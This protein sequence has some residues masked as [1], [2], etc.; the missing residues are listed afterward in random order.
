MGVTPDVLVGGLGKAIGAQGGFVACSALLRDWLW[1]RARS[2]VFS[3]GSSPLVSAL[4]VE[5]VDAVRGADVARA[6]LR[7]RERQLLDTLTAAGVALPAARRGPVFPIVFGSEAAVLAAAAVTASEGVLCQPIRPP[8]VPAGGSRLRVSLRADMSVDDVDRIGR[9]IVRAW[10][11]AGLPGGAAPA[12]GYVGTTSGEGGPAQPS[13][14]RSEAEG[15]PRIASRDAERRELGR[16]ATVPPSPDA[17]ADAGNE[18]TRVAAW[19]PD[20]EVRG[21]AGAVSA[22]NRGSGFAASEQGRRWVILGTGTGVGKTYVARALVAAMASQERAVAGL[23]PI[24]TGAGSD[25]P[26]DA[27]ALSEV[28]F[29]VKHPPARPLYAF[30]DPVT[31][32]LAARRA[33][34]T[35]DLRA[36]AAWVDGVESVDGGVLDVVVETAGG[37]FSPIGTNTNNFDLA[38]VIGN[39]TWILVAPDRLGVLHDVLSCCHAMAARGRAPDCL[40]LSAPDQADAST[41]TNAA[42][43]AAWPAIPPVLQLARNETAPL[44]PFLDTLQAPRPNRR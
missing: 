19:A 31:P 44:A 24:E 15:V 30:E 14:T 6:T 21:S 26:S 42:E 8:T 38:S 18:S 2:L 16:A 17:A 4:T 41:G 23:K 32:A 22:M 7:E 12:S 9:A 20:R 25:G 27:R 5:R 29:H 10:R 1:N 43:L 36:V 35:I 13:G 11:D 39:A 28:S 33:R 37:V 34:A 40:I 3:T